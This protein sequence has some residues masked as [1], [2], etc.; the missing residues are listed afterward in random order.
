M[1]PKG[2]FLNLIEIFAPSQAKN[3]WG[4]S[5]FVTLDVGLFV[6][7]E[8]TDWFGFRTEREGGREGV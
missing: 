4:S 2:Q 3:C 8:K 6:R 1:L 5:Q 7:S